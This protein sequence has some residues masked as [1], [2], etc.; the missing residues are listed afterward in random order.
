MAGW[1]H[2]LNGC[3][4][5]QTPGDSEGEGSLVC[6]TQ[7]MGVAKNQTWLSNPTTTKYYTSQVQAMYKLFQNYDKNTEKNL[8]KQSSYK[9]KSIQTWEKN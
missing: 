5:E 9:F 2:Q 1:R 7:S 6:H 3:E 8:Y 4:L